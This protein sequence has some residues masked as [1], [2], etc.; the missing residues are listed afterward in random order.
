METTK[1][2]YEAAVQAR[3]ATGEG[4]TGRHRLCICSG[5]VQLLLDM[6]HPH[7]LLVHAVGKSL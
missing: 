6:G 2:S 7:C 4:S 1:K 5:R 3:N